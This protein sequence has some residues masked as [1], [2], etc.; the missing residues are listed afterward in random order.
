MAG[1]TTSRHAGDTK[2]RILDAAET[3]FIDCGYEAMSLRQITSRAEANLAAVNYH[4]GSKESLIHSMLS[5]RLDRL[6]E[7]RVKLLDRFDQMLGE[8]LTCEHVLGAMFIPALRLSRDPRVGGKAFLR[9]LGRAYTDPSAFIRDF[10]NAHYASVAVRFFDAFQRA[11]PHLPREELGWRLHFAIGALSGVLAGAD[12]ESLIAE[13]SQGKSMNDLQLIARLASLMVAALKAP[14]PDAS[15]LAMFAAVLGDATDTDAEADADSDASTATAAQNSQHATNDAANE[16]HRD[17][18]DSARSSASRG[19]PGMSAASAHVHAHTH[20]HTPA[21][22][23]LDGESR[24]SAIEAC[25]LQQ[26]W[27]GA[28]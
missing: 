16:A 12:T 10:L 14:L 24:G 2:S 22:A 25:P 19:N 23:S 20:A 5:R 26:V 15:Q 13:F 7:E 8:R 28:T 3:L 6:N 9:L 4:F 1:R 11:L 17:A 27:H 18:D 21:H